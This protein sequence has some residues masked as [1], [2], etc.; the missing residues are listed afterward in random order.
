MALTKPIQFVFAVL[1][2]LA[3]PSVVLAGPAPGAARSGD[4]AFNYPAPPREGAPDFFPVAKDGKARCVIVQPADAS[5]A[6]RSA[7]GALQAYL[8][9]ATG[10]RFTVINDDQTVPADMAAIYVGDTTVGR[11]TDLELPDL[12][13]GVDRFPNARGYLVK[14]LDRRTLVIRGASEKATEHGIVGFLRRYVGIRQYWP[15]RPGDL[16]DVVPA[17]PT[18]TLPEVEWRDWPYFFST[19]MSKRA[20][21]PTRPSLDFYRLN[22]TLPCSENYNVWLPPEKYAQT[23]PE[24]YP[25]ISDQ[26]RISNKSEGAKGWQPCISNP[27]VPRV[28]GEAVADF[29]R[30]NPQAPGINFAI[31]YGGGDCACAACRAM[32]A[33][34]TDYS[35]QTGMSDRYVKLSN[36]VCEIVGREFPSKW[37]VYLAYAAGRSAPVT[38]KPHPMLLPVL[39]SQ[40]NMF[41]QWDQWMKTGARHMGLYLHHN[42]TFFILPELDVR[43]NARR[44]RYAVASGR[45]RVFYMEAH[46]QWPF[47]ETVPLVTAEL[48]WDPRQDAD[49]LLSEYFTAFYG[50]AAGAMRDYHQTIESGYERWLAEEGEAHPLGKDITSNRHPRALEQFRV[51][52]PEEAA[53]ASAAL[54]QAA[55]KAAGDERVSQRI[56]IIRAQFQLQEMAVRWAWAAFRLRDAA[57]Q[58]EADAGRIVEDARLIFSLSRQMRRHIEETLEKPPLNKWPLFQLAPSRPL[59]IYA[60]MKSGEPGPEM[61][62]AVSA[63]INAAG[64][65][66]R[67]K[68]GSEQ[69]AAW[70]RAQREGE[71]YSALAAAFQAAANRALGKEP[72]N[73][74]TDPGFEE[75]GRQLAPDA[76]PLERDI[77]L[78]QKQAERLG[79]H[80]WFPDRSPYRCALVEN[81]AHSG[82]Y[83]LMI[84]HCFR[85]RFS[86]IAPAKPAARYRVG[87]WFRQSEGNGQYRFSVDARLA[88]GSY[89]TLAA[90]P[91][92]NKPGE[93]REFVTEVVAPPQASLIMLRLFVDRQAADARCWIDDVLVGLNTE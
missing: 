77:V 20:F 12:R 14:T 56:Q 15:G 46:T 87:I 23:H 35:R 82:R 34:G 2:L 24:F 54:A 57:P 29:F 3:I 21:G 37:I 88:D 52:I 48:L 83:A 19:A 7:V 89:P 70:W 85:A 73:L 1:T 27:E 60:E 78:D 53:R 33:P 71:Q 61:R 41:A 50:P 25:L 93:W 44:I 67:R 17:R 58:S 26:R 10:A 74:L 8:N 84:E 55:A 28:M 64:D 6:A 86:R 68:L 11:K 30:R 49:A 66:L 43:H 90:I 76:F 47:A 16:G 38:V 42:D 91:I 65:F 92:P 5:A 45:A 80:F 36:R 81:A 72:K 32:D 4:V 59:A 13:Y 9:L 62:A 39:T 40:G 22:Q 63:G 18:L 69:A 31:N 51:L 79:F 75:I